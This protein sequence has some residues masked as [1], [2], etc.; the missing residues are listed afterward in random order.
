MRTGPCCNCSAKKS[1]HWKV[2]DS[3]A[4]QTFCEAC[5]MRCESLAV[6]LLCREAQIAEIVLTSPCLSVQTTEPRRSNQEPETP[7]SLEGETRH[8]ASKCPDPTRTTRTSGTPAMA[9]AAMVLRQIEATTLPPVGPDQKPPL[10]DNIAERRR[11]RNTLSNEQRTN[12]TALPLRLFTRSRPDQRLPAT[13]PTTTTKPPCLRPHQPPPRFTP[14]QTPTHQ[15]RPPTL[16]LLL[17]TP[18]HLRSHQQTR[19]ATSV[20]RQP[21]RTSTS[22]SQTACR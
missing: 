21:V 19:S 3:F 8:W 7:P 20:G 14:A 17:S 9:T 2:L 6:A 13:T 16:S 11:R 10:A 1:G 4:G 5:Y 15:P 22:R 18:T 12:Q